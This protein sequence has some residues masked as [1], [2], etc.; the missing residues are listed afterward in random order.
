M[1]KTLTITFQDTDKGLMLS[2]TPDVREAMLAVLNDQPVSVAE[3]VAAITW[4]NLLQGAIKAGGEDG[5]TSGETKEEVL[6][7][8]GATE[9]CEGDCANCTHCQGNRTIN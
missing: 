1:S 8:A 2:C 6:E 9:G 7:K 5:L 4:A 3:G